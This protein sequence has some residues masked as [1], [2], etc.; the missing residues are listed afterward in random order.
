MK[1]SHSN[2]LLTR[3]ATGSVLARCACRVGHVLL[4][5][6]LTIGVSAAESHPVTFIRTPGGGIHPQAAVDSH[7]VVHLIY[8]KGDP[9]KGDIFY[10]RQELGHETFSTPLQVNSEPGSVEIVGTMRGPQLA[11]G[12]KG[13]VHVVWNGR[14]PIL[15]ARLN[16]AG[17]AFEPER[18]LKTFRSS[19]DGDTVAADKDGNVYVAWHALTPGATNEI[20]RAV[21][22]TR[23]TDEGKTFQPEAPATS[24]PTGACGCCGLRAFADSAGAVYILFR[25]ATENVNRNETL[26]VSPRPGSD[27]EIAYS[28]PWKATSC[29]M[30]SASLTEGKTGVFA[31]WEF[32]RD[33]LR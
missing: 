15:Y 24:K 3:N 8:F 31:A 19:S 7:G 14:K 12:K 22:V 28:H 10:V 2:H 26:L 29:P 5:C 27:F 30:S 4:L 13:R 20:G 18:T 33:R 23:S 1:T 32:A 6:L 21:Y 9:K 11:V 25:A 16:D 17:T